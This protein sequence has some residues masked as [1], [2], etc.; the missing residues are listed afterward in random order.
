M[1][2]P[3]EPAEAAKGQ[4]VVARFALAGPAGRVELTAGNVDG[5]LVGFIF[6]QTVTTN[7]R[8]TAGV[9]S[10]SVPAQAGT[11]SPLMMTLVVDGRLVGSRRLLLACDHPWFFAPRVERCPFEPVIATPAAM[12]RFERGT[13]LWLHSA[14]SIYVLRDG[15]GAGG[16]LE[17]FDDLFEEGDPEGDARFRPPGDLRQPVRGFGRLW[18][19][20][21]SIRRDLGWAI[22]PERGYVA[23]F[24]SAFGGW[25]SMRS[26]VSTP[27]SAVL[28]F[29][30]YYAPTRW[31]LLSEPDGQP[32]RSG[33]CAS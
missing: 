1:L 18:R 9:I 28:E 13:M 4:T 16:R 25:K 19:A 5:T 33:G 30:T 2:E 3:A 17:R 26:Y 8:R 6:P 23:C 27:D 20:H 24:G 32:V 12:Q 11:L 15:E 7:P 10:F 14:D 29:E 21:E 22:E 31:R